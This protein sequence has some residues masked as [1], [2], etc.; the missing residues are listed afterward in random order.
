MP[1]IPFAVQTSAGR[2][3]VVSAQRL[4]NL[5]PEM[6]PP[7][8]KARVTLLGTPGMV[9][10]GT[11][12]EGPT[13]G[14]HVMN[15][16]LYVVAGD[17][18]YSVNS[19]GTPQTIGGISGEGRVYMADN[20]IQLL[21]ACE[22]SAWVYANSVLSSVTDTDFAGIET[23]DYLDGYG[24]YSVGD[25][26]FFITSLNDFTSADALDFA[27]A[28]SAP[29][30]IV[31]VFVDHRE[32]W[33]FGER[34]TEIWYNSGNPAFPFE[35]VGGAV[36]ERG[37][38]AAGSVAK[39]DNSTYWLGDDGIVYRAAG[40]QPERISTHAI[41]YQIRDKTWSEAQAFAYTQ[42]GHAFYVLTFSTGTYVY[43]AATGL[44]HERD[45]RSGTE[46]IGRWRAQYY[47]Y[48]YGKHIVGDYQSGA[49][50]QLDLSTYDEAGEEL[51][52]EAISAPMHAEGRRVFL[53]RF[54][55]DMETGVGLSTGQ[56]SDPQVMLQ[57]SRDGG[58]TW[59]TELWRSA[60]KI[61]EYRRRVV[62]HRCGSF[63]DGA[64]RIAISDPVKRSVI[65]ANLSIE[66]GET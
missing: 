55:L 35:R 40:Y 44:W 32:V 61:G 62:W 30:D 1:R 7:D 45:S 42:E 20:G 29:D 59:G 50:Y 33:L 41:E 24:L 57:I 56:G 26:R 47:A 25:G 5:Y 2:S 37:C 8:A 63:R 43:D 16:T 23:C 9:A 18:L 49:L 14:M 65:A 11:L 38:A 27:S 51:R 21:M 10:F 53:T 39:L 15:G 48:A 31:R 28:E 64:L 46:S 36:L 13:R 54:E 17:T 12:P 4:I 6:Q 3:S 34:T 60:G 66:A 22:G 19:A 52:A 58:R